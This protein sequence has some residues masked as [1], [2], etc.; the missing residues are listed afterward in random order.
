M[1]KGD[2]VYCIENVI[3]I[4]TIIDEVLDDKLL[5]ESEKLFDLFEK[6]LISESEFEKKDE[7]IFD[8]MD[9]NEREVIIFKK[10]N[11]YEISRN[12]ADIIHIKNDFGEFFTFSDSAI[13]E[14]ATIVDY[15]FSDHFTD[16]K[17]F[18][19]RKLDELSDKNFSDFLK[20]LKKV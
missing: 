16:L 5:D 11:V 12:F 18:R 3:S 4:E 19:K 20:N 10:G 15:K 17:D 9:E 7:E 1:K 14:I 6:G 2:K 8:R 13:K